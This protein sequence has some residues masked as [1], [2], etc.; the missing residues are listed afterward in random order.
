MLDAIFHREGFMM[1]NWKLAG[2]TAFLA[3]VSGSGAFADVTPED[4][5]QN[6]QDMSGAYGQTVVAASAT[7]DGDALVV[8]GVKISSS[9]DGVVVDANIEE[10]IFTDNGDG[11]VKV[12]MSETYPIALQ[13]PAGEDGGTPTA[14]TISISQPGMLATASGMPEATNYDFAA[15]TM[16]V[17]LEAI[18]GVDAAAVDT[19]AEATITALAGQ[20]LIEGPEGAKKVTSEFSA[21][22]MAL[23]IVG[24]DKAAGSTAR[25]IGTFADLVAKTN[26]TFLGADMMADLPAALK[27][28]FAA[29]GMF[30]YGAMSLDVDVTEAKGP[31]KMMAT[32]EGGDLT[33]VLDA[34]KM[35]YGVGSKGI[36]MTV[37]SPDI[38]FPEL[39]LGYSEAAFNVLMPVGTSTEPT[40]FSLLSKLVGFTISDEVWG[41]FDPAGNL[42]HDP[43]TVIVD[44][45]GK[46]KMTTDLFDQAAMEALTDTPP[47][48]L[49]ALDVTEI[50]ASIA[51]AELTGAGAFTFDNSDMTTFAG[52]PAPNG[53]LDLKLVGGNGL[54]DKL[55]AMGLLT[56]EDAMGARMMV[57]MFANAGAEGSD[58][59]TSTIEVKDKVLYA[60]GQRLQ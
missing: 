1:K 8:T 31:F 20:Y 24:A 9:Q 42:P 16:T 32:G 30:S 28:G 26:G 27:A 58:E 17:K 11:T 47:G 15:P 12:I 25:I 60:N 21:Q 14:L 40:D 38:P 59:L 18:E 44:A 53:K 3:L 56:D 23:T 45:K 36:N 50:K 39:K 19:T 48:E 4:V 13:L 7:R 33:F 6:W 34:S 43:A 35:Q 2:S 52:M 22:S 49:H 10:I 51:G 37:S 54:L 46:V 29:D 5:W 55:V 41:M 57:A